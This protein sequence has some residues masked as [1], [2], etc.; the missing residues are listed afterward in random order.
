[1]FGACALDP[2]DDVHTIKLDGLLRDPKLA[3]SLRR[4]PYVNTI[5]EWAEE[6]SALGLTANSVIDSNDSPAGDNSTPQNG[7]G[8]RKRR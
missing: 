5:N 4:V 2:D 1:M 7:M 6:K 3:L 8:V